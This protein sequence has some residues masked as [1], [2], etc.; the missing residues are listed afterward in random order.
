[1]YPTIIDRTN[2]LTVRRHFKAIYSSL[3]DSRRDV[4]DPAV[5]RFLS[6]LEDAAYVL[7][8]S[9]RRQRYCIYGPVAGGLAASR[10][11][12]GVAVEVRNK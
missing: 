8:D 2:S 10:V 6:A 5:A 7:T 3:L 12:S 1:M 11:D 4:D 9:S